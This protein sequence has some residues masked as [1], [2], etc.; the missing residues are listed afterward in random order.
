MHVKRLVTSLSLVFIA[1]TVVY[2]K[3]VI[4]KTSR[5]SSKPLIVCTTTIIGDA[6]KNIAGD[7][8]N[9][10]IL[11]GPGVDPHLYKPIEQD[12]YNISCAHIIFYNGLHLEARMSQL[13]ESMSS[14]KTTIAIS[15]NMPE[16]KLIKSHEHEQFFDPH[17]WFDPMLWCCSIETITHTLQQNYP[18]HYDLYECNKNI[19]LEKIHETYA[20]TKSF[21]ERIPQEKRVLI[22]GHDAFSYFARAYDFKVI[23]LQ[24]I[25]TASEAGT[26]DVQTLVNFIYHHKIPAIFIETSVPSRSIKALEQGVSYLGFNV[27]I[28]DELFSDALG[29]TDTPQGTYIGMLESNIQAIYKGLKN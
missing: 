24:G 2:W 3:Q 6:I 27:Q 25:S 28:G 22:T 26:K 7:S 23:G 18:H 11:M 1:L 5:K 15:S 14:S 29:G 17:V 10:I 19:Y 16:K 13:F 21:L 9:L 20:R 4:I 12:V 8:V